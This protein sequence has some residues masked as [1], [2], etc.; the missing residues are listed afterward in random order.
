MD[1]KEYI[2]L[3]CVK[4]GD[5]SLRQVALK[6][7]ISPQNLSNKLA[8]NSFYFRDIENI[9]D[10]LDADVEIKFISRKTG[11]PII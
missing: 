11:E 10:A 7:G 6:A 4:E 5:V 8:K 2:K 9:A 3:C 1:I